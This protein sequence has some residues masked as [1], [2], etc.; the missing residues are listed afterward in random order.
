LARATSQKGWLGAACEPSRSLTRPAHAHLILA[1][2]GLV[3]PSGRRPPRGHLLGSLSIN[4]R[5]AI[6][7][8]PS[9]FA[10]LPKRPG[11]SLTPRDRHCAV[12]PGAMG[13]LSAPALLRASRQPCNLFSWLSFAAGSSQFASSAARRPIEAPPAVAPRGPRSSA[14]QQ[15]HRPEGGA[16]GCLALALGS[17]IPVRSSLGPSALLP[18]G[19]VGNTR[20]QLA[21]DRRPHLVGSSWTGS[22]SARAMAP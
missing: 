19:T 18:T 16:A 9:L 4:L 12:L 6:C 8:S 10:F 7:C 3:G 14:R 15:D 17:L 5:E 2:T 11:A 20:C 22:P 1:A 21:R 13:G